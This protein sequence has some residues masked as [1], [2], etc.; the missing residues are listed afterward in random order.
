M[1]LYIASAAQGGCL[2]GSVGNVTVN[3]PIFG[4][5]TSG[6]PVNDGKWHQA[7]LTVSPEPADTAAR[8][9]AR[10]RP[11][12]WTA[13]A[14]PPRRSAPRPPQSATGYTVN[15]GNGPKGDLNGSIADVSIYTSTLSATTVTGHYDALQNQISVKVPNSNPL[16]PPQYLTTPTLN[17]AT[18]TVTGPTGARTSAYM[19]AD[20]ALV[21]VTS[22]LGGVTYYGYDA[23]P[24]GLHD[25]R[26]G[27]RHVLPHLRR[28][29]QRDLHDHVRGRQQLPDLL[30]LLLREPGEPAGPAQRQAD[31]LAGRQVLL[32]HRPCLRHG[33]HL[34]AHRAG[35][36][37]HDT[38][39]PG[40]P[41]RLHH[42]LHLHRRGPNPPSAAGPSLPACSPRSPPPAAR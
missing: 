18:I 28:A 31:R 10:P 17:T 5:C 13:R 8:T 20:G 12:T 41:G 40:L 14:S 27:R 4:T 25:H 21:Q 36:H 7:V 42:G 37:D 38:A 29:Q 3:A 26:P 23:G 1:G 39:D 16:A 11:C 2:V 35:R 24:A 9:P 30:R 22:P 19:Y 32:V 15:I 6:T 33:H 34:H